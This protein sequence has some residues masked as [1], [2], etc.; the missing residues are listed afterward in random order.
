MA[1]V[2]VINDDTGE[3][4][5]YDNEKNYFDPDIYGRDANLTTKEYAAL[6]RETTWLL[7]QY[8][9]NTESIDSVLHEWMKN[10]GWLI[11]MFKKHPDYKDGKFQ[12]AFESEIE[13]R[14]SKSGI[15]KFVMWA[16]DHVYEAQMVK[17]KES[18]VTE[19]EYNALCNRYETYDKLRRRIEA[20]IDD[21]HDY[22][23]YLDLD[24]TLTTD[25]KIAG[26]DIRYYREKTEKAR[27][28]KNKY[29]Y[30]HG[31]IYESGV[32][33]L[34][35]KINLI[36]QLLF[37]AD[38]QTVTEK[39]MTDFNHY[40]GQLGI[41]TTAKVGQKYS[42][43]YSKFCIEIGLAKF[44]DIQMQEFTDQNGALHIKEK[45]MGFNYWFY[46]VFADSINP[47]KFKRYTV[48]S[49]NP[50]DYLTMSFGNSWASCH[51]IDVDQLRTLQGGMESNYHGMY[52]SGTESYMLD[53]ST[54]VFYY[55]DSK[56]DGSELELQDKYKRCVFYIGENK[57]VQSRVYPDGRD[58]QQE[59]DALPVMI[60]K[61]IREVMEEII[62]KC[63]DVPN[64]WVY[65]GGKM[66]ANSMIESEGTHYRDYANYDD[67]GT[68]FLKIGDRL[69]KNV[70]M[71]KV[72]H[73]PICPSCGREHNNADNIQCGGCITREY[74]NGKQITHMKAYK[75]NEKLFKTQEAR[76]NFVQHAVAGDVTD[77]IAGLHVIDETERAGFTEDKVPST[78]VLNSETENQEA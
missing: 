66:T 67:C 28:E 18:K 57:M 2:N 33:D 72:G 35:E 41:K 54:I 59:D 63:A 70:N 34:I 15:T 77:I 65:K 13:R 56:Y 32:T 62:S 7:Q 16:K 36:F 78:P 61:D 1:I 55:V 44:K 30:T 64:S 12:I 19:Q 23:N 46:S 24:C 10:K 9:Y 60:A 5:Q 49:V 38:G 20:F 8:G 29:V 73:T 71:I 22:T 74:G 31:K 42:K 51:T 17:D 6:K 52:S 37:T 25:I 50:I 3:V 14:I 45:D 47:V 21:M 4:R 69:I 75:Y 58:G 53:G 43:L 68:V 27:K 26:H 11:N 48:V 40:A 76:D 39:H